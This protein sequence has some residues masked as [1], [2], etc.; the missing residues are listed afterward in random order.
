MGWLDK[1]LGG[2]YNAT[3]PETWF[4]ERK[5]HFTDDQ[6]PLTTQFYNFYNKASEATLFDLLNKKEYGTLTVPF[7]VSENMKP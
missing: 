3:P 7:G 4:G 2:Y 1:I 5:P 6:V